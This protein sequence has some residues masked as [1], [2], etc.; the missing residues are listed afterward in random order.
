MFRLLIFF[1]IY[2]KLFSAEVDL[3]SLAEKHYW[4]K[5]LH[6]ENGKS[7][8]VNKNFFL[9]KTGNLK[10]ELIAT[11]K[12]FNSNQEKTCQFPARYKWLSQFLTF[13]YNLSKCEEFQEFISNNF[14]SISLVFASSRFD[15]PATLFGHIFFKLHSEKIDLAF[16]YSAKTPDN[17]NNLLYIFNGWTGK[18]LGYFQVLPYSL[19]ETEYKNIEYRNLIEYK[20]NLSADE[21]KLLIYHIFEIKNLSEKYYFPNRNCASELLKVL[22]LAFYK[23]RNLKINNFIFPID[24]IHILQQQKIISDIQISFSLM[25]DFF[26]LYNQLNQNEKKILDN[27]LQEHKF[28]FDELNKLQNKKSKKKVVLT[29]I[30]YYKIL[31]FSNKLKQRDNFTYIKLVQLFTKFNLSMPNTTKKINFQPLNYRKSSFG[32]G[33]DKY[34]YFKYRFL[35]RNRNDLIDEIFQNGSMEF[36]NFKITLQ[37]EKVLLEKFIL[38]NIEAFPKSNKF[39]RQTGK[40]MEIGFKRFLNQ[41]YFYTDIGL[42]YNTNL[43]KIGFLNFIYGGIYFNNILQLKIGFHSEIYYKTFQKIFNLQFELEEFQNSFIDIFRAEYL[44]KIG[45]SNIKF[46]WKKIQDNYYSGIFYNFFF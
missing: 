34:F 32:I 16:N 37:N 21:V 12:I 24:I 43:N 11:I 8:I 23:N 20:L 26:N 39:F 36:L 40:K 13:K 14:K 45:N 19:K 30:L 38:L 3:E 9:S 35:Y 1:L 42:G 2:Q 17:E 22:E 27:I 6:F 15:N 46:Y 41:D 5:L 28:V 4:K 10:D 7:L 18:Y 25:K 44:I 33:V 31:G 29:G